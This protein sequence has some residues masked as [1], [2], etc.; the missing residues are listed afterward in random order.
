MQLEFMN[1]TIFYF[2]ILIGAIIFSYF[3]L[4][5]Q[6]GIQTFNQSTETINQACQG[7]FTA[8]V[9]RIIDGD[10]IVLDECSAHVRL[11]L[12][13]APEIGQPGA[14]EATD[15]TANLCQVGS[16][17]EIIQDQ[18]QPYDVYGRIV[19]EVFCQNKNLNAELIQNK[20]AVIETQYCGRSEF[21]TESWAWNNGCENA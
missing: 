7:N 19:A 6:S 4:N 1:K 2:L 18:G 3:F 15:F 5:N 9:K 8:T 12:A 20:L 11:S 16:S 17:A 13:N 21:Q 10:T 14:D